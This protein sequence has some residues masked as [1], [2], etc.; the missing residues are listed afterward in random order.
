MNRR[1]S[2]TGHIGPGLEQA[3]WI[4]LLIIVVIALLRI[5]GVTW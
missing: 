4:I 3:V 5:S 2:E 1:N